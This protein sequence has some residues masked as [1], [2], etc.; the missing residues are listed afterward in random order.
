MGEG[1]P[2]GNAT[3]CAVFVGD[4]SGV[5]VKVAVAGKGVVVG[6]TVTGSHAAAND[7]ATKTRKMT[8][9]LICKVIK[10]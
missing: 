9:S 5:R 10:K 2:V 3:T 6:T 4:G 8:G 7:T 1:A